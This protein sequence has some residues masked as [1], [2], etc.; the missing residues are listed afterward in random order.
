MSES[1]SFFFISAAYCPSQWSRVLDEE[2]Q[3]WEESL[4]LERDGG[5]PIDVQKYPRNFM[6][7][8]NIQPGEP[9]FVFNFIQIHYN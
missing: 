9:T 2:K 1:N 8:I 4:E 3:L 7:L 6:D 5:Y